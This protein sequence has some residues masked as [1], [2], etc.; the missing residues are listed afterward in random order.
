VAAISRECFEQCGRT[1][2]YETVNPGCEQPRGGCQCLC[3]E[4]NAGRR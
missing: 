4:S 1:R 3:H 2:G